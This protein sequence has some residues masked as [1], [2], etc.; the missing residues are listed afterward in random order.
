MNAEDPIEESPGER[1]VRQLL[2]FGQK[3]FK[4]D[5][6]QNCRITFG[7]WS[8][9]GPEARQYGDKAMAGTLRIY[10]G[11]TKASENCI[12][13]FSNVSGYR[14]LSLNYAEEIAK[15][16]GATIWKSDQDG[17]QREEKVSKRKEW[18]TPPI[19][20]LNAGEDDD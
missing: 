3:T 4:I 19:P 13:V 7:P 6:P 1:P 9:P 15:E 14:D 11:K 10:E 18:V 17:Y 5:L 16:E 20:A 8:P 2:V 12:A